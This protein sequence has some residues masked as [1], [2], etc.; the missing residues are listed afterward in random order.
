MLTARL[1]LPRMAPARLRNKRMFAPT[2][3]DYRHPCAGS[4]IRTEECRTARFFTGCFMVKVFWRFAVND[5]IC[6]PLSGR[7]RGMRAYAT[8][9]RRAFNGR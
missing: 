5:R 2:F 7:F 1:E 4:I 9:R 8:G 3:W 6:V